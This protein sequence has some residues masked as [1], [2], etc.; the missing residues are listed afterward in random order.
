MTLR[1]EKY[2]SHYLAT[3]MI[4]MRIFK[5]NTRTWSETIEFGD[6]VEK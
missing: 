2:F 3:Q 6:L 1:F 5:E 4:I